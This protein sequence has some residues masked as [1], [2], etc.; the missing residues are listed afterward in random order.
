MFTLL[1]RTALIRVF[2]G[3]ATANELIQKGRG[4]MS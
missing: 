2:R 4:S 1:T 3:D